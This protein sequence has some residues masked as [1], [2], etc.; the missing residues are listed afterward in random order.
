MELQEYEDGEILVE[1]EPIRY[2]LRDIKKDNLRTSTTPNETILGTAV[3]E[4]TGEYSNTVETVISYKFNKIIYWGTIEGV[5]RGLPTEVYE[6][7]KSSP[8]KLKDGWGLKVSEVVTEVR[9]FNRNTSIEM[10]YICICFEHKVVSNAITIITI[11]LFINFFSISF[12]FYV[13]FDILLHP[14]ANEYMHTV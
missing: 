5:A 13:C 1:S 14:H 6:N 11:W 10:I 3:L 7:A 8:I 12:L 2:E 4:N 9:S